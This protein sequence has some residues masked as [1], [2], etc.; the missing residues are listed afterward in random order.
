MHD[1]MTYA[2]FLI[3]TGAAVMST[4]ALFTRQ[5]MLVG[6]MVLG[7]ILGPSGLGA[8]PDAEVFKQAGDVGI[9]FL[10]FLVGLHLHP[11]KLLH[12]FTKTLWIAVVSSLIFA[13]L[14]YSVARVFSYDVLD[15]MVV[16]A[17]MMFSSTIIGLKLLPTTV[18]H[19][20]HT[21]EIVISALLLQDIIAIIVLLWLQGL[22]SSSGQMTLQHLMMIVM[23]FPILIIIA[24]VMQRYVLMY[25]LKKFDRIQEYIFLI[26]IGWC[27]GMGQLADMMGLSA[28]IGAFI[29]GVAVASHPISRYI[30]ENLKPLRDFFLVVFFFSIGAQFNVQYLS[31]IIMPAIV[32]AL[33]ALLVKP[34]I[35]QL[36]FRQMKEERSV[37][38]EVGWRLGQ[39]SEFSLLI[40]YMVLNTDVVSNQVSYLIQAG[41]IVTFVLTS[42]LVVLRYPSPLAFS[43]KLRRD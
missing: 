4:L 38:W 16:G 15:S 43:E 5:S 8:I 22:S 20:R 24:Y 29:A 33:I 32:L 39:M 21:G 17:S 9:L 41:T 14:G 31:S 2:I 10:L 42:Y 36:L 23:S 28:S 34:F 30:S 37:S 18:L 6:Y 3:F 1:T 13:V 27:A 7:G 35:F 19:H 11:Q 40:A 25:L 12:M 26:S